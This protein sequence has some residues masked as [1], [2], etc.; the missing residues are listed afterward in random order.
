[1]KLAGYRPTEGRHRARLLAQVIGGVLLCAA[2]LSGCGDASGVTGSD[3]SP[4]PTTPAATV[5]PTLSP[6]PVVVSSPSAPTVKAPASTHAAAP[7][8]S[9]GSKA[10]PQTHPS[11]CDTKTHY[12]NSKGSC[13]PRPIKAASAP[14]GATA[15]CKDGT[16]SSSQSRRGTC[17]SHG[18]VA[19]WL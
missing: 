8:A 13:V 14:A 5:T 11:A 7:P 17:S 16:Y 3:G 18:G 1:M 10:K 2:L 15:K 4:S 9:S 19:A 6:S 12:V